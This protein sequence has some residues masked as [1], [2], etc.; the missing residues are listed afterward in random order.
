MVWNGTKD[1]NTT[2]VYDLPLHHYNVSVSSHRSSLMRARIRAPFDGG[3][4]FPKTQD[5]Q[6][7]LTM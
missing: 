2:L 4:I 7:P 1:L 5:D 3:M 6:T